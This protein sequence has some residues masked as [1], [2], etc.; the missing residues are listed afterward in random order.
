MDQ[1]NKQ[2][3]EQNKPAQEEVQENKVE[4]N[5]TLKHCQEY[6]E[7]TKKLKDALI[8]EKAENENLRK[9]FKRELEEAHKF[10]IA[11]FVKSIIEQFENLFRAL[12][13]VDRESCKSHKEFNTLFE[14]VEMSK[15][16]LLKSFQEFDINRIYPLNEQFDH[17]F[18]QAISQVTDE[19]KEPNIIV[20]VVQAGYTI[21]DKLLRPA[22]V[23]VSKKEG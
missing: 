1:D 13:N 23:I 3:N 2:Q 15:N 14:G 5:A 19:H 11:N 9:R 17:N 22:I 7:E 10:G 8:R 18:H 21:K 20:N 16:N 12:E 6:E 4:D